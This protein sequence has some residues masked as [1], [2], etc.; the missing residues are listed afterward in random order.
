MAQW[1]RTVKWT[2]PVVCRAL[3]RGKE[4]S[5]GFRSGSTRSIWGKE[6]AVVMIKVNVWGKLQ[7]REAKPK[8]PRHAAK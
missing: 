3:G 4:I 5:R 2:W 8:R 7:R 1:P 6:A